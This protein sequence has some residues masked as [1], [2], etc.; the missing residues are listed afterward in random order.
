MGVKNILKSF[1]KMF[2]SFKNHDLVF[3]ICKSIQANIISV[4]RDF[5]TARCVF[6]PFL[7]NPC[8]NWSQK[9]R[10]KTSDMMWSIMNWL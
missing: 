1:L 5:M 6:T 9:A 7:E 4:G 8:I 2:D 10:T 3:R